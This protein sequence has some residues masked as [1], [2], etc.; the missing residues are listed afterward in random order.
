MQGAHLRHQAPRGLRLLQRPQLAAQQVQAVCRYR[1]ILRPALG[2]CILYTGHQNQE[3]LCG[4]HYMHLLLRI[5]FGEILNQRLMPRKFMQSYS[6]SLLNSAAH[7]IG[8]RNV[9]TLIHLSR[10]STGRPQL[11]YQQACMPR[12]AQPS[13][14]APARRSWAARSTCP[15]MRPAARPTRPPLSAGAARRPARAA[16]RPATGHTP[17]QAAVSVSDEAPKAFKDASHAARALLCAEVDLWE[18]RT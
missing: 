5:L 10:D 1:R 4:R 9:S 11:D 6:I 13:A 14:G 16:P 7:I 12:T 17:A 8:R 2:S 15:Q 18:T 3:H